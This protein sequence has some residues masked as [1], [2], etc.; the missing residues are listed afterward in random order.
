[1]RVAKQLVLAGWIAIIAGVPPAAAAQVV[2]DNFGPADTYNTTAGRAIFGDYPAPPALSE[3]GNQFRPNG[4]GFVQ[5]VTLPVFRLPGG[6]DGLATL[7]LYADAAGR[8]GTL[9]ETASFSGIPAPAPGPLTQVT[10]S[11]ATLVQADTPYW[12]T[13]ST[14]APDTTLSWQYS[15]GA[16]VPTA[17][18]TRS[19][20]EDWTIFPGSGGEV[21]FR[22][23]VAP[24]P[25]P[26]S[27][28]L[29]GSCLALLGLR[30][31]RSPARLS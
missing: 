18:A 25:E 31:R 13:L 26:S 6:T 4:R 24:V 27:L 1:M 15:V 19:P 28:A 5:S 14:D 10:W 8:P 17:S 7:H 30:A 29:L 22:V 9:L 12:L 21:T 2:F 11:G 16:S 20:G 3:S 23:A